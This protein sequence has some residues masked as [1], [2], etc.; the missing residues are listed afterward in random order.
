MAFETLPKVVKKL[1]WPFLPW[2]D[3][4]V[5]HYR[6]LNFPQIAIFRENLIYKT[7]Q[8]RS[9]LNTLGR[10]VGY[11]PAFC[12]QIWTW[13]ILCWGPC[14]SAKLKGRLLV[15]KV[16]TTTYLVN[17]F[18]LLPPTTEPCKVGEPI[19]T[20]PYFFWDVGILVMMASRNQFENDL[21]SRYHGDPGYPNLVMIWCIWGRRVWQNNLWTSSP[22]YS[23]FTWILSQELLATSTVAPRQMTVARFTDLKVPLDNQEYHQIWCLRSTYLFISY[24]DKRPRDPDKILCR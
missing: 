1:L 18:C 24:E 21:R 16:N 8:S 5:G 14:A 9:D 10:L 6:M 3:Q 15:K 13:L 22:S 7:C 4:N 2:L 17:D 19:L 20:T 12:P 23:L 11:H